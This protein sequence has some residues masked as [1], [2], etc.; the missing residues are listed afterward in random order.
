MKGYFVCGNDGDWVIIPDTKKAARV[1]KGRINAFCGNDPWFESWGGEKLKGSPE[2]YGKVIATRNDE[3]PIVAHDPA[4]W[5]KRKAWWAQQKEEQSDQNI[6]QAEKIQDEE[7][8]TL[9]DMDIDK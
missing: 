4:L 1:D 6:A 8:W 2:D 3:A 7:E 9:D 5:E